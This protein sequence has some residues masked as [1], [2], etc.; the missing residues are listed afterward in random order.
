MQDSAQLCVQERD[1]Q[2]FWEKNDPTPALS[3]SGRE[4]FPVFDFKRE[5]IFKHS[6]VVMYATIKIFCGF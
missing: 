5:N 3:F 1:M 6:T 4:D 2:S